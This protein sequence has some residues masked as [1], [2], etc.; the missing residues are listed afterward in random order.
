MVVL[1]RRLP[2]IVFILVALI[3]LLMIGFACACV[4]DHRGQAL[5]HSLAAVPIS[6]PT[7][8]YVWPWLVLVLLATAALTARRTAP[9][10]RTAADF[11]RFLF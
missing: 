7:P 9:N 6:A 2:L 1:R 11:Q 4:T 3:C 5:E 10:S 8:G